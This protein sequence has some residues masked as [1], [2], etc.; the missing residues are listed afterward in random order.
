MADDVYSDEIWRVINEAPEYAV[1]NYGRVKRIVPDRFGREMRILKTP[2][3][4][5]GYPGCSLHFGGKQH[6]R[7]VHRLVCAAF[8]GQKPTPKHEVRHLDGDAANPRADNLAWGTSKEN[9]ADCDRHGTIRRG[10]KVHQAKL[11]PDEVATIRASGEHYR[12]VADRFGITPNYV[13]AIRRSKTWRH[14]G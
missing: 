9:K 6:H 5:K 7:S 14:L 2:L 3:D 10:E 13:H 4:D 12:S 1:S 8:H 11:T